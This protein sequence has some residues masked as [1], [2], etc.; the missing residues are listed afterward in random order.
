MDRLQVESRPADP[1]GQRRAVE[2]DPLAGIDLR[3]PI[4]WKMI[5]IFG[6][7]NLR[8]RGL[9]R[10][11]AFDQPGGCGH[12]DHH[13]LAGPAGIFGPAHHQHAELGRD[14]VEPLGDILADPCAGS[15]GSTG[16]PCRRHR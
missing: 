6:D 8:H 13:V 15:P 1:V 4:Q 7:Q 12:L 10:Q 16:T 9:R 3:L 11:A 14:D 2:R 5:G